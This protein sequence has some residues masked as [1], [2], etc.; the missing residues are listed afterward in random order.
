[1]KLDFPE[2]EDAKP[3]EQSLMHLMSCVNGKY[4][5]DY[6]GLQ[7][8]QSIRF[9]YDTYPKVKALADMSGNSLNIVLMTWLSWLMVSLW[10]TLA[11]KTQTSYLIKNVLSAKNG[12]LSRN[13]GKVNNVTDDWNGGKPI[14]QRRR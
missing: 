10:I 8:A 6:M 2:Y 7:K 4:E 5:S 11:T 14:H 9:T 13:L 12:F 1:M 3:H